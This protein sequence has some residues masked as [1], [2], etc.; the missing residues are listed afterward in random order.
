MT[1]EKCE[2]KIMKHLE[3]IVSIY[4][5]YNPNGEYL[6]MCFQENRGEQTV[7]FNNEYWNAD[8]DS[9]IDCNKVRGDIYHPSH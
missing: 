3:A 5:K 2:N 4:K 6:T 8:Y 1:R 7:Y 9:P